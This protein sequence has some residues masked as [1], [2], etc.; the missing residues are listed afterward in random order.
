MLHG[1]RDMDFF[2]VGAILQPASCFV[3][4]LMQL[5][6][7]ASFVSQVCADGRPIPAA[8]RIGEEAFFWQQPLR[9][10]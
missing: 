1:F 2:E 9:C 3:P 10:Y 7:G 6:L 8:E 4:C 5:T